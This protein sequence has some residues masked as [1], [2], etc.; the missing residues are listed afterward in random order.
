MG[1]VLAALLLSPSTSS[2]QDGAYLKTATAGYYALGREQFETTATSL[3][4]AIT[5]PYASASVKVHFGSVTSSARLNAPT[6]SQE[7][8]C[9]V[10]GYWQDEFTVNNPALTGQQGIARFTVHLTGGISGSWG[11]DAA[12]GVVQYGVLVG[13][14]SVSGTFSRNGLTENNPRTFTVDAPFTYGVPQSTPRFYLAVQVDG[15]GG[16][17]GHEGSAV[18]TADLTLR[19]SGFAVMNDQN[20]RQSF[21]SESRTGSSRGTDI[22]TGGSFSGFTLTN[23]APDRVGTSLSLLD[24]TAGVAEN[25]TAAFVAP[26]P[27]AD[28]QLV[29]DAV[30]VAG[31]GGDPFVLQLNYSPTVAQLLLFAETALRLAWLD[32]STGKWVNAVAGNLGG[33]PKFFARA[34][35]PA[36]DFHRGYYGRDTVNHVVWAVLD[37]NSEFGVTVIPDSVLLQVPVITHPALHTF[38]LQCMGVPNVLNRIESSPD[39]SLGSFTPLASVMADPAGAFGYDDTTSFTK[40]FYRLALP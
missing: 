8:L 21:T 10:D 19:S 35:N 29:S 14:V 37:H 39:L 18:E 17:D 6:N 30:E 25:V 23:G 33:T 12:N 5:D 20:Q 11:G 32:S 13:E 27:P 1:A 26:P 24:G 31:T 22:A 16:F 34:Y 15:S 4:D 9:H 7:D 3:A 2:A 28:I 40:K 38:H 36:T